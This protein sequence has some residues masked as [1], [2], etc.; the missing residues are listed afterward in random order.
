MSN[1][2]SSSSSG[3]IGFFGLLAIVF[4]VLKL[5]GYIGWP[6]YWV[7]APVWIPLAIAL[8]VMVVGI[9]GLAITKLLR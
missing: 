9:V 2:N 3:G 8:V 6:W 4:I 5:T 7:L 1:H